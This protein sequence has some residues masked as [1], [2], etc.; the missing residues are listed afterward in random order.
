MFKFQVHPRLKYIAFAES[1]RQDPLIYIYSAY[2]GLKLLRVL[3]SGSKIA[4][5]SLSF[6]ASGSRLASVGAAPDYTLTI[7]DWKDEKVLL[8]SKAFSQDVFCVRYHPFTSNVLSTCGTGHLKSWAIAHSFTGLKLPGS[9]AKFG[10]FPLADILSLAHLPTNAADKTILTGTEFSSLLLW[11][12]GTIQMEIRTDTWNT[13]HNGTIDVCEIYSMK[14]QVNTQSRKGDR[15]VSSRE[16][17]NST[18]S[19]VTYQAVTAGSD[20]TIRFWNLDDIE[21]AAQLTEDVIAGRVDQQQAET[22]CRIINGIW[23]VAIRP[24]AVLQVGDHFKVCCPYF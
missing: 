14:P 12:G 9:L 22:K 7:W 16:E 6:D 13:A 1:A 10:A 3:K 18:A 23:S 4:F 15:A 8:R 11:R 2:P 19:K 5:A 20:G 17:A 21:L 24:A